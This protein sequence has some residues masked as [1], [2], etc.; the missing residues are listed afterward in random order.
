MYKT[1]MFACINPKDK[2]YRRY[3]NGVERALASFESP[4][5]EWADYISFLGR[6]LKA[7]QARPADIRTIPDNY[8]VAARLAQCLTP[9]LPPGVHRKAIDVYNFIFEAI[10]VCRA[11]MTMNVM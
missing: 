2:S 5:Q 4:Q 9:A 8:T 6:L 11:R 3:A 7:L 10:G 1:D